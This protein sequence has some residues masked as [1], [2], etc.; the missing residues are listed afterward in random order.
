M[1]VCSTIAYATNLHMKIAFLGKGGSGKST[2]AGAAARF[3]HMNGRRVLAIDADHNMDFSYA[4]GAEP[5]LF[6][7]TDPYAIKRHLGLVETTNYTDTIRHAERTGAT[8]SLS[9]LDA[10]TA[11]MTTEIE[12]RLHLM[13]AGPHTDIVRSGTHCSH[14][15]AAPLKAYLPFL[16]LADDEAVV[17][18][19]R[20]GTDPVATGILKGV[21]R[22]FIVAEPTVQS[23]R[24]AGQ[25]AH[26][27]AL[28]GVPFSIIANKSHESASFDALPSEPVVRIPFSPE[29]PEGLIAAIVANT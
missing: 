1:G 12:P 27:L 17:I 16:A 4:L 8:F 21:D 15:L 25:I 10:F 18:D 20:A 9:P 19:E 26:E 5:S 3:L 13:T 24:V 6:L 7:G 23:M 2:L 22:A 28:S 14:S 29:I 11:A